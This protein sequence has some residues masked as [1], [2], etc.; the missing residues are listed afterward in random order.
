MADRSKHQYIPGYGIP[1]YL[2]DR[3]GDDSSI[4]SDGASTIFIGTGSSSSI[5]KNTDISD[6]INTLTNSSLFNLPIVG[7]M[8]DT[9]GT[10]D[11][12]LL[13]YKSSINISSISS[14]SYD[15]RTTQ[16]HITLSSDNSSLINHTKKRTHEV[17][18]LSNISAMDTW[19]SI[20]VCPTKDRSQDEHVVFDNQ[21]YSN[22]SKEPENRLPEYVRLF[23]DPEDEPG[24]EN[25]IEDLSSSLFHGIL[26]ILRPFLLFQV[27]RNSEE[28]RT[29]DNQSSYRVQVIEP[30]FDDCCS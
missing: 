4:Y 29:D 7:F 1:C 10:S 3:V 23:P 15:S 9:L 22:N 26:N 17:T 5:E 20:L 2:L 14:D 27:L 25:N 30:R 11:Q 13:Q 8:S 6:S 16:S 19:C 24:C 28:V 21:F 12:S 18:V